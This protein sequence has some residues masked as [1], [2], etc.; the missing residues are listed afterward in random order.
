MKTPEALSKWVGLTKLDI[1]F[2]DIW[3]DRLLVQD[4]ALSEA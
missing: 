2:W 1:Y 3:V 4:S